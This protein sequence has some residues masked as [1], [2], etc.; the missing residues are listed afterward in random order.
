MRWVADTGPL[1]HLAEAG[2]APLLPC[3][4][5]VCIPPAV[6][7]ELRRYQSAFPAFLQVSVI[8]L[9][10]AAATAA[11]LWT[12]GGLIDR[13]EAE[14]IALMRQLSADAFLTDDAGARVFAASLGLQARGSLGVVL[15]LAA[16]RHIDA[17]EANRL[18]DA[19][20]RSSLWLSP[21]VKREARLAL[22]NIYPG[23]A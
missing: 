18:L 7:L 20:E 22:T 12:R 10:T 15:W 2:A 6:G 3:L 9:D 21:H 5:D 1:L 23:N 8:P 17:T 19:V 13:G 14:A 16:Q 4:G 11:D